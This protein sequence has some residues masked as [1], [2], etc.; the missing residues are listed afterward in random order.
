MSRINVIEKHTASPEQL[1]L[2]NAIEGQLG[3]VPNFLK[4]FA[5]SPV[6]L[7]AFLGLHGVS[8]AG[9]LD[10][11]NR[12]RIALAASCTRSRPTSPPLPRGRRSA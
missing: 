10:P 3:M 7:R 4:V 11:L 1:E 2:L 9:Q 12:G 5:N 6:A 8:N